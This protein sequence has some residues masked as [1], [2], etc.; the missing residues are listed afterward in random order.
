MNFK[1]SRTNAYQ[2]LLG[3]A[4]ESKS[5]TLNDSF[6]H[7]HRN[8]TI[9]TPST[10]GRI[11]EK[12]LGAKNANLQGH[13][14]F[15]ASR[16]AVSIGLVEVCS[17]PVLHGLRKPKHVEMLAD[18]LWCDFAFD[19][20]FS[21]TVPAQDHCLQRLKEIHSLFVQTMHNRVS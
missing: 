19:S 5:S 21:T 13:K 12:F 7:F 15:Q 17:I 16:S 1:T 11:W 9:E 10:E 4:F 2:T 6:I 14:H 18:H 8:C 20:K 3:F